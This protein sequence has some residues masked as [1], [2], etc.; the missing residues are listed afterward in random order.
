[1]TPYDALV[2]EI[3]AKRDHY[4]AIIRSAL[5]E[6]ATEHPTVLAQHCDDAHTLEQFVEAHLYDLEE[7][8]LDHDPG[9]KWCSGLMFAA[10][11]L[12][13]FADTLPATFPS[14]VLPVS[15][16]ST[17]DAAGYA[18][19]VCGVSQVTEKTTIHEENSQYQEMRCACCGAAWTNV[20]EFDR[21]LLLNQNGELEIV[22]VMAIA[23]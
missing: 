20:W 6:C 23:R 1:M 18:C 2:A 4:E 21:I 19:P 14:P 17:V 3:R 11:E 12:L 9:L 22:E 7:L 10:D 13:R 15:V 16:R 8:T 5:H